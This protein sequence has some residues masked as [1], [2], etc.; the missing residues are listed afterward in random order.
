MTCQTKFCQTCRFGRQLC[1]I[2]PQL[3]VMREHAYDITTSYLNMRLALKIAIRQFYKALSSST[4]SIEG[5]QGHSLKIFAPACSR[6]C[7]DCRWKISVYPEDL[8]GTFTVVPVTI[9]EKLLGST[10]P[11]MY[12]ERPEKCL[13]RAPWRIW[14]RWRWNVVIW[15]AFSDVFAEVSR[16]TAQYCL[17]G[18]FDANNTEN[19]LWPGL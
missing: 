15:M 1:V 3:N 18:T 4:C 8:S 14:S 19:I 2:V 6:V 12:R 16:G 7:R 10:T 13:G 17:L 11:A 5:C 9:L